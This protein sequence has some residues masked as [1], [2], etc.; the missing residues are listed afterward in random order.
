ML[1]TA[2]T[3]R[4][5]KSA[6]APAAIIIAVSAYKSEKPVKQSIVHLV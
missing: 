5:P 2:K 4:E 1:S 6:A 3:T